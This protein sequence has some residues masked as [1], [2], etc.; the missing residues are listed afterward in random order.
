MASAAQ[1]SYVLKRRTRYGAQPGKRPYRGFA[2]R[3]DGG[4]PD[5]E[6][7]FPTEKAALNWALAREAELARE[8]ADALKQAAETA[9][10]GP[11]VPTVQAYWESR[12][13]RTGLSE[14]SLDTTDA[15]F[16][17][18][19]L[20]RYGSRPL[21]RVSARDVRD[22][23]GRLQREPGEADRL[24]AG[25]RKDT[26]LVPISA[27]T[28][29]RVLADFRSLMQAAFE[30]DLV[31]ANP[32]ASVKPPPPGEA[33]PRW[34][35]P[36]SFERA[37]AHVPAQWRAPFLTMALCGT[38][39]GETAALD[40]GSVPAGPS[41]L[42][43]NR[44]VVEPGRGRGFGW[45]PQP[46]GKRSREVPVPV[47]VQE[48]WA[49]H[50]RAWPP[51]RVEMR[52]ASD[53]GMEAGTVTRPL[54]FTDGKGRPLSRWRAGDVWEAAQDAAGVED[55]VRMHD[56]RHTYASILLTGGATL[57][58][59]GDLMGHARGSRATVVYAWLMGGHGDKARAILDALP[60]PDAGWPDDDDG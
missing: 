16:R 55:R 32:L 47:R 48:A 45:R 18:Y 37:V 60:G 35:S 38:R 7:G 26:T 53:R 31:E 21:D 8:H 15:N 17:V 25:N 3:P 59:V 19:V 41:V 4:T 20:H 11:E 10:A 44:V 39:W 50:R 6:S 24:P 9:D 52:K 1:A 40:D 29:R 57:E 46:K 23:L 5:S 27:G 49:A 56:L 14:R 36:E 2:N 43:V 28:A 34:M 54:W 58:E 51:V 22:W 12:R 42:H 33:L 30:D 13:A